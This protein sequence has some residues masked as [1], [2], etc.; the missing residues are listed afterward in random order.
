MG[1]FGKWVRGKSTYLQVP[2]G[3]RSVFPT[4][5]IP[6]NSLPRHGMLHPLGRR[7]PTHF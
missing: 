7:S 5:H 4:E 2:W 1:H 3:Y 6:L